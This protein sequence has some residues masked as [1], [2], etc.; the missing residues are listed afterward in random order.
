[1]QKRDTTSWGEFRRKIQDIAETGERKFE[2]K[3]RLPIREAG[4][5]CDQLV[6]DYQEAF[7]T[8]GIWPL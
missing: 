1:M 4:F 2:I 3:N 7:F 6:P 8:P 5:E